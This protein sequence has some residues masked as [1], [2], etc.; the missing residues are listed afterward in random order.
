MNI[1]AA[2]INIKNNQLMMTEVN[3]PGDSTMYGVDKGTPKQ[4]R[5]FLSLPSVFQAADPPP[6]KL[7]GGF[8]V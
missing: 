3:K 7:S 1:V 8:A 4:S 5:R 6:L 2:I